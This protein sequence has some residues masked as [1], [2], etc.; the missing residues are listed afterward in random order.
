MRRQ[1]ADGAAPKSHRDRGTESPDKD[2]TVGTAHGD[3]ERTI[4]QVGGDGRVVGEIRTD[5]PVFVISVAAELAGMHAQTLRTYDREGLV[6]PGRTSGGGRRYSQRDIE[7]LQQ[8]QQLSQ[9]EGVNRAG[10]RRIIELENDVDN[11]R[12]HLAQLTAELEAARDV[13]L[14]LAAQL[15][16]ADSTALVAMRRPV[17]PVRTRTTTVVTWRPKT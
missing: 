1:E 14:Q 10:I 15:P 3:A 17:V 16:S 11:L 12:G 13:A 4:H 2:A 8:V 6:T 5:T 7:L 9:D